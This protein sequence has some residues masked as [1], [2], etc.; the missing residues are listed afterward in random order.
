MT[1]DGSETGRHLSELMRA[2][3][4]GDQRAYAKLL[5]E[6]APLLRRAI[7]SQR[8][9]LQPSDIEDL[10]QDILL[11]LHQARDL[12]SPATALPTGRGAT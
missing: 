12:R 7:R 6:L 3:Q 5:Q 1:N 10:V 9:F 2:A 8:G 11:S 4:A